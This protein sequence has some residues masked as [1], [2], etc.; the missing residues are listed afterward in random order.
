MKRFKFSLQAVQTVRE[1][2]S[3]SA[4]EI[5]ARA[6][7]TRVEAEAALEL[8][9]SALTRHLTEWR[10]AMKRNFAPSDMLQQE[11]LRSMLEARRNERAQAV[12]DAAKAV[13]QAQSNFQLARQ[14]SEIVEKFRDRQRHDF[15]LAVL[16]DEQHM[17]DELATNRHEPGL[18]EKGY[19]HA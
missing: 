6:L 13:V 7:R 17:L 18:F 4:L 10:D 3:R 1:R 11:H 14:K 16:K 19:A 5:Y 15:N 8:A 12:R 2:A 9:E